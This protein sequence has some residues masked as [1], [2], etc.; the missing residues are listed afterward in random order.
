MAK[1]NND[2][3]EMFVQGVEYSCQA[4]AML[5]DTLQHYNSVEL[6][7]RMQQIHRVEHS[8]DLAKHDMMRRLV[9]EFITPIEREDIMQLSNTIDDVTDSIEDVLMRLYMFNIGSIR[10]E[11][12]E[13]CAVIVSCCDAMKKMMEEFHNFRKSTTIRELIININM[14]EEDGDR[15][16]TEAMR[17][18]YINSKDPVEIIAWTEAFDRLEKCCD[19]C[20]D[21][22][23]V[24]ES[25]IM[26]NT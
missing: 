14:L 22:A 18:L 21:V 5:Q 23:N 6:P 17:N 13:F 15:I 25:V 20:E 19:K 7:D 1:K 2:Y 9:K 10:V 12:L 4:A 3:F 8:A 26:K 11:A 24:I 16:Y